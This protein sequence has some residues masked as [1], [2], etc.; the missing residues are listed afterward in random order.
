M[1]KYPLGLINSH[2]ACKAYSIHERVWARKSAVITRHMLRLG[3]F[4]C[5]VLELRDRQS[6]SGVPLVHPDSEHVVL[7]N[8]FGVIKNL[9]PDAALN[10][11][12]SRMMSGATLASLS[13]RFDFWQKQSRP[14][15]LVEGSTEVDLVLES[16]TALVFIEVKRSAALAA[17]TKS[18]PERHQLVRNLDV[19]YAR[20]AREETQFALVYMTPD[21]CIPEIVSRIKEQPPAFPRLPGHGPPSDRIVSA[22]EFLGGNC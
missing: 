3:W 15:G 8:V 4:M 18:D 1:A 20:A 11:W 16:I 6:H 17:G 9:P 19:G 10:P 13:W 12:L 21:Q 7:G 22:L 2:T 14:R 5:I